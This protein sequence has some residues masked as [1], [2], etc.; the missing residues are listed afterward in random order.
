VYHG[1]V[2]KVIGC[3]IFWHY[4]PSFSSLVI[5]FTY[6]FKGLVL[7]SMVQFVTFA[8]LRFWALITHTCHLFLMKWSPSSFQCGGTCQNQHF[9][10][11]VG[12]VEYP[13]F[14]TPSCMFSCPPWKTCDIIVSSFTCF[15]DGLLTWAKVCHTFNKCSFRCHENIFPI[16]CRSNHKCLVINLSYHTYILFVLGSFSHD[17]MYLLWLVTSYSYTFF[18]LSTWTYHFL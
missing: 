17:V 5:H 9:S 6:F 4:V 10:L 3:K 18:M 13:N 2:G 11:L 8:F 12:I 15:L 1:Y 16:L 7:H 14:I